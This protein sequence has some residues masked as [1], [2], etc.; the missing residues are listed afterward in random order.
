MELNKYLACS[1]AARKL[2]P[3]DL[4]LRNAKIVNVFTDRVEEGNI[5]IT[6]GM[7]VG[8]GDY[9]GK[10][11]IDLQ[12][13]YVTS[14]FIDAHLHLEST[15][16]NPQVLISQAEAHGTTTFIVDPHEVANV[17][18]TDGIDYLLSQTESL[19]AHVY[20]MIASCVPATPIDDNGCRLTAIDMKKYLSNRR[21]LGLGEVMDCMSVINGDPYMNDKLE[22]FDGKV[23]DG[24]AP[25]LTD[26]ELAA[27]V[28]AG[29]TT[30][31]E[32]TTYEYVMKERSI[33][34][35]CHIREGSAARNLEM[36][37]KGIVENNTN[38]EGFCFCTDDKHIEDISREGDIDHNVRKAVSMGISPIA[39][40][41]MAT[42][43]PA[44]CYGLR[45]TGAVAPGYDADL[46]V[47]DSIKDFNAQMVF[48]KG[49]LVD[50]D[51]KIRQAPCPPH[52]MDTIHLGELD[53]EKIKIRRTD[54]PFPAL[55]MIPGQILTE[56]KDVLLPGYEY[57]EPNGDLD[58]I[59][60]FERHRATGKT[61]VGVVLNFGLKGGAIA[62]S[63]SHD[64]HNIIVIGDND[65]DIL[66]A[67]RELERAKGG[68]T[69]IENGE[70]YDTLELPVMGLIS[71]KS[72]SYVNRKLKKMIS[73]AHKMGVPK[74]IDP[75][76]TLSF[77]ALPVI[78]E[79]RC[80]PRGIYSVTEGR[81]LTVTE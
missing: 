34:M 74:G 4:V 33:G 22:L 75:F 72:Y 57:F 79:I 13:Q 15:L 42:I 16:V 62:S 6:R 1:R 48:Y 17:A 28:M 30:D 44:R 63:V 35:T 31:H 18:G 58:K 45:R 24:H 7:I 55:S 56:R 66:L 43:Q 9:Q 39:A 65:R 3:A 2:V 68:Y 71:D 11:E 70:V 81:F 60:V 47:W 32:G 73:H 5:A 67:V 69:I 80:T 8:I 23:K 38:T 51:R 40:V 10:E 19:P 41:K 64:S 36:I 76:I 49:E 27:Y 21:V 26:E 14:G 54:T 29:V 25:N 12:G 53:P 59:A 78:P 61:G 20:V 52:L 46:V 77:M 37:V 50:P